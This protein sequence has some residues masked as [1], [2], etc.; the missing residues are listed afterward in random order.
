MI[1]HVG[2]MEL[3]IIFFVILLL[4]GAKRV[5]EVAKSLGRS[6]HEFKRGMRTATDQIKD[7]MNT[8]SVNEHLLDSTE[9]GDHEQK[10]LQTHSQNSEAV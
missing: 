5:P 8:E 6:I 4:F 7:T 1:G 10:T 3:L 9:K 2:P